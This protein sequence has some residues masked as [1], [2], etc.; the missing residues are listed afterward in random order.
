MTGESRPD[1]DLPKNIYRGL[2]YPWVPLL[3]ESSVDFTTGE[4]F[5]Y[6]VLP[7][8]YLGRGKYTVENGC[9]ENS[10]QALG[11]FLKLFT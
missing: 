8:H 7:N 9:E 10:S 1:G 2:K 5:S 11:S 6:H 4:S 3:P